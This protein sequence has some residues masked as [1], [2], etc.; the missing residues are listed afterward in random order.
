MIKGA[1]FRQA[2]LRYDVAMKRLIVFVLV[3]FAGLMQ[4]AEGQVRGITPSVTSVAPGRQFLPGPSVTSLGPLGD[5]GSILFGN[6]HFFR[7]GLRNGVFGRGGQAWPIFVPMYTPYAVP[8]YPMMYAE[9]DA[10]SADSY[11]ND[12][13]SLYKPDS[14]YAGAYGL[15]P[16]A[17][18][19]NQSNS[20]DVREQQPSNTAMTTPPDPQPTT[21]LV[22]KDGH[23]LEVTNYVIQGTTLF[24]L[25]D[26]GPRKVALADLDVNETV[27]ENDNRGVEFRL[28]Q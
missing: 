5:N 22:F 8:A 17:Q 28:P 13:S 16:P 3:M 18:L 9:P 27:N 26:E 15:R 6:R 21:V 19:R 23:K 4:I 25:G 14:N 20:L 10:G 12:A 2:E 11:A 1:Q 7:H 24:N